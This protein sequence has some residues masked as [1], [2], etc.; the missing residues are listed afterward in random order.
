MQAVHLKRKDSPFASFGLSHFSFIAVSQDEPDS[1]D[2]VAMDQENI[3]NALKQQQAAAQ[4]RKVMA[5][6]AALQK[7]FLQSNRQVLSEIDTKT[8]VDE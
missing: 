3:G 4:R 6:M 1:G 5:E 8:S 7:K 2:K